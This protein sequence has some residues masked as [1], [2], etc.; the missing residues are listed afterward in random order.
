MR[1]RPLPF[2]FLVTS[3]LLACSSSSDGPSAGTDAAITDSRVGD[4]ATAGETLA[5]DT[6]GTDTLG[7][8]TAAGDTWEAYAKGFFALYCIECHSGGTRDFRTPDDVRRDLALI[9]C[10]VASTTQPGCTA[11]DPRAKQFPINNA[12]RTNPKPSDAERDRIVAWL[13]SGAP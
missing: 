1:T 13:D 6:L 9:R 7:T 3:L 11:T 5:T 4:T 8:D 12:A 2:A 10:G